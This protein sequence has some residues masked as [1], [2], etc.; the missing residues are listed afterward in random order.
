MEIFGSE[1]V[2]KFVKGEAVTVGALRDQSDTRQI[3]QL[4]PA[5]REQS[6]GGQSDELGKEAA[7]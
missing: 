3:K 7:K 5:E 1:K 4:L 6:P 2:I